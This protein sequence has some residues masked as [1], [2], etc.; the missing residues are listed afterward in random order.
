MVN[1]MARLLT[2]LILFYKKTVGEDIM[3]NS[4][5]WF[6]PPTVAFAA[7]LR[8]D[9]YSPFES[10][11]WNWLASID[12]AGVIKRINAMALSSPRSIIKAKR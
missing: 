9:R 11:S 10:K 7:F 3:K 2:N 4:A 6:W 8:I 12:L 5:L 1:F